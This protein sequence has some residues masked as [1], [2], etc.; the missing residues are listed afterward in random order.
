MKTTTLILG[1]GDI[2]TTLGRELKADGHKV[3]G[4][5]RDAAKLADSGLKAV[6]ADL[7]DAAA[8]AE[9][10]D[11]E[12]LVYVVSADRFEEEAYRAAYPDGL[13]AVLAE[14]GARRHPPK[15]VFFVSSTSVYAQQGGETVDEASPTEP[16]GFSGALMREAEQALIDHDLPGTVVRFSGIYG[17]GRDRL[18]RQ[19]G[20]GRIAAATPPMYSNRIHRDDCAG[21]LAHLIGR[22]QAGES[23][24]ELYLASDCEP[25]PLHEVMAWLA[26]QLKVEATET[27]QSPLRRRA[28][29]RCD[30]ARLIESGY[31]FRFPTFREG[32]LQV[33]R[34][35]GYLPEA[36]T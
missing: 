10:P 29:K 36:T 17:P 26:K 28:S 2:G 31:R 4:V 3:I 12:V 34:E 25:A 24:H 1:C 20:E 19:V 8:L 6:S 32:Y 9:L 14:F 22:A 5:R 21:V 30:N 23:L 16:G 7:G 27:I 13:K 11:A 15:H 18:I 35:G 33:L